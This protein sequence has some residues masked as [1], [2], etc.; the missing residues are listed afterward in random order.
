MRRSGPGVHLTWCCLAQYES[1]F[2]AFQ[3]P[4]GAL[5]QRCKALLLR[6]QARARRAGLNSKRA[7]GASSLHWNLR[8]Q[9]QG[10][11]LA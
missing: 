11:W 8:L 9:L 10:D 6:L 7:P 3:E 5:A 4:A 2:A 1:S